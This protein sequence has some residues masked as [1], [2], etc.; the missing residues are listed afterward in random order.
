M[1]K[2]TAVAYAHMVLGAW[3]WVCRTLAHVPLPTPRIDR[4]DLRT[5]IIEDL[6]VDRVTIGVDVVGRPGAQVH[7]HGTVRAGYR[8][9]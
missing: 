4:L 7:V 9:R 3:L 8:R 5:K 2:P 6:H 1:D